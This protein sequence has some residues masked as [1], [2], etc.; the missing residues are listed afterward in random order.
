MRERERKKVWGGARNDRKRGRR[1][2]KK[3]GKTGK[4]K[5]FS[6]KLTFQV[7]CWINNKY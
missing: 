3:G 4:C 1:E 2:R 5:Q 7:K 6:D